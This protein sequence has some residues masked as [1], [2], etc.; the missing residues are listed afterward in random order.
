VLSAK[1]SNV[2]D[3]LAVYRELARRCD[4]PLHLGLTEAGM[5][6][7]GIVVSSVALGVLLQQGI[8]DTINAHLAAKGLLLREGTIVDTTLIAVPP[9]TKNRDKARDPE[10]HQSK[11]GNDWHFGMKANIYMK[12]LALG[13]L[14]ADSKAPGSRQIILQQARVPIC[15]RVKLRSKNLAF[16]KESLDE[17][18]SVRILQKPMLSVPPRLER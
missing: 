6:S 17:L 4:F 10:K 11:K 3:L 12:S 5:G 16:K 14:R 1:V 7:K 15:S 13:A 2:P 8:G 9:S 18:S